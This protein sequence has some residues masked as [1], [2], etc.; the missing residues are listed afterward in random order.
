MAPSM[1]RNSA[2]TEIQLARERR[3]ARAIKPAVDLLRHARGTSSSLN[4]ISFLIVEP[5]D[6]HLSCIRQPA[7]YA[8]HMGKP[9]ACRLAAC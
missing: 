3:P 8:E 4:H 9:P 7:F 1:P 5:G 6:E 2:G